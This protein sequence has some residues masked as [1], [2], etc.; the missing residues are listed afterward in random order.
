MP[1]ERAT[2]DRPQG[3]DTPAPPVEVPPPVES[4]PVAA[5]RPPA[6]SQEDAHRAAKDAARAVFAEVTGRT[7][8]PE[9]L[10]RMDELRLEGHGVARH[11]DITDQQ[12]KDRLG[13]PK[14]DAHGDV[15]LK[16]GFVK[17]ENHIDPQTGTTW[18]LDGKPHYSGPIV[19]RFESAEDYVKAEAYL[20]EQGRDRRD[21][22]VID[23]ISNILGKDGEQRMAGLYLDPASP[24]QYREDVDF[25]DGE[26][27][28]LYDYDDGKIA[29]VTMYPMGKASTA[30]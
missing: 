5:G 17:S 23:T 7:D 29:Q 18:Q 10:Q 13:T 3:T 28:A 15:I 11:Y 6:E 27:L 14:V 21:P 9:I 24:D 4:S 26:I 12:M 8:S 22:V 20:R 30:P 16:N 25:T 1:L 2:G 19:T